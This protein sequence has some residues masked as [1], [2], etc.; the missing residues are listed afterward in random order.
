MCA[1]LH[2]FMKYQLAKLIDVAKLRN[3]PQKND[4]SSGN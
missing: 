4:P 3:K 1:N 2:K